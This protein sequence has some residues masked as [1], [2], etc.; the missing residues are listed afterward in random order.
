MLL[1]KRVL[2]DVLFPDAPECDNLTYDA[3]VTISTNLLAASDDLISSMY[4]PQQISNVSVYLR[5]LKAVI[6]DLQGALFPSQNNQLSVEELL[7]A[8]QLSLQ[9]RND[10]SRKWF[11]TC[12]EQVEIL[13][14]KIAGTLE[15]AP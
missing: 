3:L 2:R 10:K 5:S 9:P 8:L 6:K 11:K 13:G 7:N 4:A 14:A 12:F 15:P 1:H